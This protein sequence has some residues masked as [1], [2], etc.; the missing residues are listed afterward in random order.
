[1]SK[2]AGCIRAALIVVTLNGCGV[3]GGVSP[4]APDAGS[5]ATP[6][7]PFRMKVA[8]ESYNGDLLV[9]QGTITGDIA[10]APSDVALRLVGYREGKAVGSSAASVAVLSGESGPTAV[11]DAGGTLPFRYRSPTAIS[12]IIRSNFSGV[13]MRN[14]WSPPAPCHSSI[15]CAPSSKRARRMG[16][17]I[18]A[19]ASRR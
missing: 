5:I 14:R 3:V 13:A 1:M 7:A 16:R 2:L 4:T 11:V 10:W 12:P 15:Q 17:V 18:P 8:D 19:T 6:Q 9:V